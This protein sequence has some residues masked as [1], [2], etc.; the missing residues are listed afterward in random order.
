MSLFKQRPNRLKYLSNVRTLHEV[1]CGHMATFAEKQKSKGKP[2]VTTKPEAPFME[3][4]E[5]QKSKKLD[6]GFGV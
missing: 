2:A 6:L 5:E 1:H 3:E 4:E